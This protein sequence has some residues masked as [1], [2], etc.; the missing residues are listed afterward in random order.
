MLCY[1]WLCRGHTCHT[2]AILR[3]FQIWKKKK[4]E[5][6][7]GEAISWIPQNIT[8]IIKLSLTRIKKIKSRYLKHFPKCL[9]CSSPP[10]AGSQHWVSL[11]GGRISHCLLAASVTKAQH[12]K[13]QSQIHA[14]A[15]ESHLAC[16]V[17]QHI[18]S[19]L[20]EKLLIWKRLL[21]LP[22]D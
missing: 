12:F 13:I 3:R 19:Y 8:Q 9:D 7:E 5:K 10:R 21:F 4:K 2:R 14:G 16:V 20:E 17:G 18:L 22:W 6:R 1:P 15:T 11:V